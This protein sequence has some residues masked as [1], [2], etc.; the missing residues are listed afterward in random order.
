MPSSLTA[1]E[2]IRL[3]FREVATCQRMPSWLV[4]AAWPADRAAVR[5]V[6]RAVQSALLPAG[7][8]DHG[9]RRRRA[10]RDHAARPRPRQAR[11]YRTHNPCGTHPK[12]TLLHLRNMNIVIETSGVQNFIFKSNFDIQIV[13]FNYL[14]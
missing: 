9:G 5:D 4:R 3:C 12:L 10:R 8:P 11:Q 14:S 1:P 7:G 2:C 6:R 13:N